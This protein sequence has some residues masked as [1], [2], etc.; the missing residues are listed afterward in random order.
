M[1]GDKKEIR[2]ECTIVFE[3]KEIM[4]L[5]SE[6][7][8]ETQVP[9]AAIAIVLDN[10]IVMQEAFGYRDIENKLSADIETMYPIASLSKSFGTAT[11]A[12]LVDEGKLSWDDLVSKYIPEFELY[13]E[14]A[15][16]HATIRD[17]LSH[18][19]GLPRHDIM[20][21]ANDFE[22]NEIIRRLKFLKPFTTFRGKYN[23]QNHMYVVANQIIEKVTNISTEQYVK[24]IVLS[25]ID[26]EKTSFSLE[27]V[28]KSNNYALPYALTNNENKQMPFTNVR[29]IGIAGAINS[30]IMDMAKYL[31]FQMNLGYYDGRSVVSDKNILE[32]QTPQTIIPARMKE[33]DATA[34]G[35]GLHIKYYR[36]EKQVYHSGGISGFNSFMTFLPN[37]KFGIVMLTNQ[38]NCNLKF[39][40]PLAHEI[41]DGIFYPD[42]KEDWYKKYELISSLNDTTK[43]VQSFIDKKIE[44]TSYSK[45]IGDYQGVYTHPGYGEVMIEI[46]KETL[47]IKYGKLPKMNLKH[48]HYETFTVTYDHL[49]PIKFNR[50]IFGDIVSISVALEPMLK[51]PIK[52]HKENV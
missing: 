26:M 19:T 49:V 5:I 13:D 47:T 46:N 14:Y 40:M 48:H 44:G 24:E 17:I 32:T 38:A 18:K 35:L 12:K 6:R 34:Y 25:P 9:S 31:I 27:E 30:N 28:K 29:N 52:F 1:N 51:E 21:I 20:W 23:Y 45:T 37:K 11:L 16:K 41:M 39:C 33:E 7:L 10:K 2:K 15:S 50:D 4:N 3:E 36:G 43:A 8:E 22:P 42:I